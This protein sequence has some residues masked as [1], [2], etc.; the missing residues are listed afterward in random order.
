MSKSKSKTAL[1]VVDM[2][3]SYDFADA[4]K[5]RDASGVPAARGADRQ[6]D[7][8]R[9]GHRA[10]MMRIN[11]DADVTPAGELLT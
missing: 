2:I 7:P 8:R 10:V 1:I 9:P 4:G 3:N 5:L 11:M 6:A